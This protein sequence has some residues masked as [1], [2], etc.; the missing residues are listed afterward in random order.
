MPELAVFDTNE[1]SLFLL[2]P[3]SRRKRMMVTDQAGQQLHDRAT[4]GQ[5]LSAD[6]RSQL[7]EW[8]AQKERE[9]ADMLAATKPAKDLPALRAQVHAAVAELV[10]LSQRLQSVEAENDELRQEI[11]A[12]QRELS[13]RTMA[14][15]R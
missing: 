9:E 7:R 14:Q 1:V 10:Q 4:R 6:E 12:L 11:A 8:Y 5:P 13:Q 3:R 15:A 2:I